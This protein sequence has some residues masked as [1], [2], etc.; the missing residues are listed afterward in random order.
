MLELTLDG[1]VATVLLCR[2]P[3]NA[4]DQ[5][6]VDL[7]DD[8]LGKAEAAAAQ[9]LVIRAENPRV[10]SAGAD[11]AMLR[12]A[13]ERA[14]G[15]EELVNFVRN[16]QD[17][18]LRLEKVEFPTIAAIDGLALGG[19]LELALAC[20]FRLAGAKATFGLTETGLGLVP[21]A[22]GTQR[23]AA[24]LGRS[25]ARQLVLTG[26]IVDVAEA[27]R[28]GLADSCPDGAAEAAA[29]LSSDLATRPARALALAKECLSDAPSAAGYLRE[30]TASRELYGDPETIALLNQFLDRRKK[31]DTP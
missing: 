26:R 19:G 17:V 1:P 22:G 29:A 7:L 28:L 23:L 31:K 13:T 9:C 3:V 24:L 11:I 14:S 18:L 21:G 6:M 12:A 10:F 16:F 30:Q 25:R 2:A 4:F 27:D 5:Q 15:V 20:D 8:A